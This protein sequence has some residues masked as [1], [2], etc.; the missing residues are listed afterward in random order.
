MIIGETHSLSRTAIGLM[1]VNRNHDHRRN[2]P[3]IVDSHRAQVSYQR[4]RSS[5]KLT[6][7]REQQLGCQSTESMMIRETHDSLSDCAVSR[8]TWN[9]RMSLSSSSSITALSFDEVACISA[10]VLSSSSGTSSTRTCDD[11]WNH[12]RHLRLLSPGN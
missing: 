7:Y 3:A 4:A 11:I 1:S 5:E 6:F 10:L 9:R 2:S 12:V 8:I